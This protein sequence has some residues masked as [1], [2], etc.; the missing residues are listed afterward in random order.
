MDET[1]SHGRLDIF[2]KAVDD[3]IENGFGLIEAS[4]IVEPNPLNLDASRSLSN[5]FNCSPDGALL[6]SEAVATQLNE[7]IEK[8]KTESPPPQKGFFSRLFGK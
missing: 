5:L 4:E 7:A 3:A 6:Y 2:W 8:K 1:F